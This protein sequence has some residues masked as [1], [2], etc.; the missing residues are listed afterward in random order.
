M[1]K[2]PV[3]DDERI[4]LYFDENL[5][6]VAVDALDGVAL[7]T[8]STRAEALAVARSKLARVAGEED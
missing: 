5:L 4:V 6:F 3:P 7:A 8:C 1:T 2:R